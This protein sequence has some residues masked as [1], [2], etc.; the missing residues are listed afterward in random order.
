[1]D[2]DNQNTKLNTNGNAPLDASGQLTQPM[3]KDVQNMIRGQK[4]NQ[5]GAAD[6]K[7][8]GSNDHFQQ[9]SFRSNEH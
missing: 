7:N 2:V 6:T 9:S 1:M 3:R 5:W 4:A 8:Y